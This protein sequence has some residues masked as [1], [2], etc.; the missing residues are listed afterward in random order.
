MQIN[1]L[2]SQDTELADYDITLD[3]IS[4]LE[5]AVRYDLHMTATREQAPY[6]LS[7]GTTFDAVEMLP[8]GHTGNYYIKK[9]FEGEFNHWTLIRAVSST[10]TGTSSFD[11]CYWQYENSAPNCDDRSRQMNFYDPPHA[12]GILIKGISATHDRDYTLRMTSRYG[13]DFDLYE[14]FKVLK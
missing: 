2:P 8:S 6:L 7:F 12:I 14:T 5:P 11:V 9:E 1:S 10:G 3:L 4:H 13:G